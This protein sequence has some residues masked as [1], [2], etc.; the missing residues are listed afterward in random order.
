M[1]GLPGVRSRRLVG[2]K[3][4]FQRNSPPPSSDYTISQP[5]GPSRWNYSPCVGAW[6]FKLPVERNGRRA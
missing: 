1:D 2:G 4:T 3:P 6:R 5:K